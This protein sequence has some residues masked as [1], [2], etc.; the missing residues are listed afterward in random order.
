[1]SNNNYK[2]G[3]K[4]RSKSNVFFY[5]ATKLYFTVFKVI[6][7]YLFTSLYNLKQQIML[8]LPRHLTNILN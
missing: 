2:H 5:R 6:Q 8:S 1:M 7:I 3:L 4:I